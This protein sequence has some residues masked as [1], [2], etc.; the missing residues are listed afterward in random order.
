MIVQKV[1][2][3]IHPASNP[4]SEVKRREIV[5]CLRRR[6]AAGAKLHLDRFFKNVKGEF[7][8]ALAQ[9]GD[10]LPFLQAPAP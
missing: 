3:N 9:H 1:A 4:W 10:P 5:G 6:D 2:T 7:Q 8:S